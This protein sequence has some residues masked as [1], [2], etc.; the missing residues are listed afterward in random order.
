M[1]RQSNK[2]APWPDSSPLST[3]KRTKN[4]KNTR[5]VM[6]NHGKHSVIFAFLGERKG[7]TRLVIS[8]PT[9]RGSVEG[10]MG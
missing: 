1:G 10:G 9:V 4:C 8:L 7:V 6:G 3:G 2:E 5:L